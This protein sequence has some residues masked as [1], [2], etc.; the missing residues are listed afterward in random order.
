MA[1][2]YGKTSEYNNRLNKALSILQ[3]AA[4][5]PEY[6]DDEMYRNEPKTLIIRA[7]IN[8]EEAQA[9]EKIVNSPDKFLLTYHY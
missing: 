3:L 8:K 4:K 5:E 6:D 7:K 2:F 9:L 1:V